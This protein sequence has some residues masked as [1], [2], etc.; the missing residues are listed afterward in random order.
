MGISVCVSSL[1]LFEKHS[2]LCQNFAE[3]RSKNFGNIV[4]CFANASSMLLFARWKYEH[5]YLQES[6]NDTIS[7]EQAMGRRTIKDA[8]FL[9]LWLH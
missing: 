3:S 5:Y 2:T 7:K 8:L 1:L 6:L 4:D 9:A